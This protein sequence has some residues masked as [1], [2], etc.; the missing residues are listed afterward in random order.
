MIQRENNCDNTQFDAIIIGSSPILL[1]EALYLSS[2]GHKIAIF[3]KKSY[4]GGAWYTKPLWG[5][6]NVETGC[7]YI[8]SGKKIM[9]FSANF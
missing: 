6:S 1:I 5:M 4:L 2:R 8:E 9:I 3:E 7:H